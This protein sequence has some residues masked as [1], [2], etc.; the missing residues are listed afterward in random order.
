MSSASGPTPTSYALLGLLAI[1]PWTTYELAAQMDRTMNRFWPRARSKLYEEPKKLVARG[2]AQASKETVGRRPR[3]VYSITP[4]G[5]RALAEWVA[6]PGEGPVLENEQL[7]KVFF[8]EHG[9]TEDLLHTLHDARAWVQERTLQNIDVGRAYL[10]GQGP[11]PERTAILVL[12][13]RFLDDILEMVDR[14]AEWATEIAE[15]WPDRPG[16]AEPDLA[17][18]EQTVRQALDRSARWRAASGRHARPGR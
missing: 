8:G 11:F 1:K 9:S 16:A 12:T 6:L 15:T 17:A 3:T 5:R 14:W 18:L 10:E 13:G 4:E 7:M 2:L